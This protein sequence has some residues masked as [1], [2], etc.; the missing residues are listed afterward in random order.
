M[1][2]SGR[3]PEK[4]G[5]NS[6][7]VCV[8]FILY[9]LMAL[10]YYYLWRSWI[11]FS[12]SDEFLWNII[13]LCFGLY[14]TSKFA[15]CDGRKELVLIMTKWPMPLTEVKVRYVMMTVNSNSSSHF[16]QTLSLPWCVTSVG[17]FLTSCSLSNMK[18]SWVLV[19]SLTHK[20]VCL[21]QHHHGQR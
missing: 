9:N 5:V 14:L 15:L 17:K 20:D 18:T 10:H 4:Y 6:E 21:L 16:I 3:S 1:R 7:L 11:L 8:I 13:L 12:C 19:A 2:T